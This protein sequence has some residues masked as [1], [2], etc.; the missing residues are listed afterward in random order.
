MPA[1]ARRKVEANK[2]LFQHTD[3]SK[4]SKEMQDKMHHARRTMATCD[5]SKLSKKD[6]ARMSEYRDI[7]STQDMAA[8]PQE[9]LAEMDAFMTK[10]S[11]DVSPIPRLAS[12]SYTLRRIAASCRSPSA[13]L[14]LL[15]N[16]ASTDE[17]RGTQGHPAGD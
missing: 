11:N 6:Q 10:V 3:L 13:D 16:I 1:E 5:A 9:M 8:M 12:S 15:L 2:S 17:D 4:L 7:V 14:F